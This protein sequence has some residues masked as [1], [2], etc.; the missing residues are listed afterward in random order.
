MSSDKYDLDPTKSLSRTSFGNSYS[1]E[2]KPIDSKQSSGLEEIEPTPLIQVRNTLY[3]HIKNTSV[4]EGGFFMQQDKNHKRE[5]VSIMRRIDNQQISSVHELLKAMQQM[6]M[7]H[8]SEPFN[9]VLQL[10]ENII[11]P[12]LEADNSFI[13]PPVAG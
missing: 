5:L 11:E 9:K 10:I 7:T 13:P 8:Q 1:P 3:Q 12:H 6:A 4:S 2:T